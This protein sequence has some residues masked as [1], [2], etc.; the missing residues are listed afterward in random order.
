MHS[1]AIFAV[2]HALTQPLSTQNGSFL[3]TTITVLR[4][5]EKTTENVFAPI[6]LFER[7]SESR[8]ESKLITEKL[9]E[10]G[11]LP[12]YMYMGRHS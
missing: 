3:S 1:S 11:F 10:S 7:Q 4:S 6:V 5:G 12:Q 9:Y 2:F 8:H